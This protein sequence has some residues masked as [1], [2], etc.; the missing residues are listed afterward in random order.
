MAGTGAARPVVPKIHELIDVQAAFEIHQQ[1]QDS[2]IEMV[3]NV[4]E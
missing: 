1:P 4:S 3:L 2:I